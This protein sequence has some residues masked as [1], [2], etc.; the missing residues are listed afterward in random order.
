MSVRLRRLQ[1]EY[2]RVTRLF[3]GHERIRVVDIS[4]D[5]P[6]IYTIEYRVKGLVEEKGEI[7]ERY[8]HRAR[9]TLGRDYPKAMPHCV[10]LTTV[11]HPNIDHLTVCTKDIGYAGET[12]DQLIVLIGRMITYQVHNHKSSRNGDAARWT[13]EHLDQLPLE[14]ID[15]IPAELAIPA[16]R[17]TLPFHTPLARTP[18]LPVFFPQPI[19][20]VTAQPAREL[21][22]GRCANCERPGTDVKLQYCTGRHLVCEDCLI[23]CEGCGKAVCVLCDFKNC[24]CCR[25]L[26]C[27]SCNAVCAGCR[28]AFCREHLDVR[29]RCSECAPDAVL[30]ILTLEPVLPV[31]VRP[32]EDADNSGQVWN[33]TVEPERVEFGVGREKQPA[34]ESEREPRSGAVT[35][36]P[37]TAERTYESGSLSAQ[38]THEEMKPHISI[39]AEEVRNVPAAMLMPLRP[40]QVSPPLEPRRSG[41]AI[42][43]LILGIAGVPLV[44][45]LVGPFAI[46]FGGLALREIDRSE[47]LRG[48]TLALAGILLGVFDIILWI[49]LFVF[50]VSSSQTPGGNFALWPRPATASSPGAQPSSNST[51]QPINQLEVKLI[52]VLQSPVEINEVAWSPTGEFIASVG[53]EISV[54]LW[55]VS[56][57]HWWKHLEGQPQFSRALAV[58]PD[59]QVVAAGNDDGMIRLW[60][61]SDGRLLKTL[62]G[63]QEWV[64]NVGF[65]PDGQT[66][67][68]G[69]GDRTVQRWR[70]GDGQL[71][72]TF[73]A[74][75]PE[76]L[77]FA[78]SPDQ[79]IVG[80]YDKASR[81]FQLWSLSESKLLRELR[82][83]DYELSGSGAFSP[84]GKLLALGSAAGA[85]RL[86][87]VDNG[88]LMHL[89]E[90]PAAGTKSIAF[91]PGGEMIAAGSSDSAVWLW[92]A[93]DGRLLKMLPGHRQ[94]VT[95]VAF[96][97]DGQRLASGSQDRTIRLWQ[98]ARS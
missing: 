26:N 14:R 11:F 90:G 18:E 89:L 84:D 43:S 10:M 73:R 45:V 33:L 42:A 59:G 8:L 17:E 53:E 15:L 71:L 6:E 36:T 27:A 1:A 35:L 19:S 41:Q 37:P 44:G 40:A 29:A 5:P 65:S 69:G 96:S 97:A 57:D 50:W 2:E 46:V 49:A 79:Q 72:N 12:L 48:R 63:R 7:K 31:A 23:N 75:E 95:T 82:E 92:R 21:S 24:A 32:E 39:T 61:A 30:S 60:R 3:A 56:G 4:G 52:N 74:T 62:T 64:F 68:S 93:S 34:A 51:A 91:S 22:P 55:R 76:D 94:P 77:I 54:R 78:S 80:L 47:W 28:R 9:I 83:H 38:A 86:W 13:E 98:I 70:V 25:R 66:L 67:V 87:R 20:N 81:G 85:V 58:S 88:T 16:L